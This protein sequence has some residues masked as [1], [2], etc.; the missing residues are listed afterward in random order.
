MYPSITARISILAAFVVSLKVPM[1]PLN[2]CYNY[3]C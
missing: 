2:K 3:D 1:A